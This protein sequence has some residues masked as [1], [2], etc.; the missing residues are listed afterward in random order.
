MRH[1]VAGKHLGRSSSHRKALRRNMAAS[2]IEH[3]TIRTTEAKAKDLRRFVERLIT[4]ARKGTLH[5]R[6]QAIRMLQVRRA[7]EEG[8]E[9]TERWNKKTKR[10]KTTIDVLFS[11]IAP[12]YAD[13]PGGY[14]RIIRL[15]DRRIGDSGVQVL[16]QLVEEGAT[17]EAEPAKSGRRRKRAAK[18]H[19]AAATV[20]TSEQE[21]PE[22]DVDEADEAGTEQEAEDESDQDENTSDTTE[23]E[24]ETDEKDDSKE[25]E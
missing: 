23:T 21:Q 16:L 18:R 9:F 12:R 17:G 25:K 7:V 11:E 10:G 8:G 2:L 13:R 19:Q 22:S 1:C 3:G 6:R 15:A 20:E 24:D 14:T 5:A 4:L